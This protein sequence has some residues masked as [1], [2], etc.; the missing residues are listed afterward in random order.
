[1]RGHGA[2][3]SHAVRARSPSPR[4]TLDGGERRRDGRGSSPPPIDPWK[5]D[6]GSRRLDG[7]RRSRSRSRSRSDTLRSRLTADDPDAQNDRR[8]TDHHDSQTDRP[9]ADRPDAQRDRRGV[10]RARAEDAASAGCA[11]AGRD[12]GSAADCSA[13]VRAEGRDPGRKDGGDGDYAYGRVSQLSELV[14]QG[15][16]L[17]APRSGGPAIRFHVRARGNAG[18]KALVLGQL[19]SERVPPLTF[20]Q[21]CAS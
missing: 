5:S 13:R 7:K 11:A 19:V 15:F 3:A 18:V 21:A 8:A 4:G 20:P 14:A 10:D 12:R 9:D 2:D 17:I 1:M 16:G 6:S